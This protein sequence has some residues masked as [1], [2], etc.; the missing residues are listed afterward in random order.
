VEF[1]VFSLHRP[2]DAEIEKL[3]AAQTDAPFSYGEVGASRGEPPAGYDFDTHSEL[4][5]PGEKVWRRA[6]KALA[7]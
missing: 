3:I 7:S 5:G 4:L 2:A 6:K 1:C